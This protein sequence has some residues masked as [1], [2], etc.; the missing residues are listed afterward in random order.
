MGWTFDIV[1]YKLLLV[2]MVFCG[3]C[4]STC[5]SIVAGAGSCA[6]LTLVMLLLFKTWCIGLG[7]SSWCC[8]VVGDII[9][10]IALFLWCCYDVVLFVL[11]HLLWCWF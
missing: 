1:V 8:T 4:T 7:S 11:Q 2:A 6:V 5:V 3:I 10:S 9:V